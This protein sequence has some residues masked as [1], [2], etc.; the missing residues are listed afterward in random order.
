MGLYSTDFVAYMPLLGVK[1]SLCI[2]WQSG[3]R[4]EGLPL[5]QYLEDIVQT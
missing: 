2:P 1:H 3:H 5:R 4:F